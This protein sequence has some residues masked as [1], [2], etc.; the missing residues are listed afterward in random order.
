MLDKRLIRRQDVHAKILPDG[1]VLLQDKETN[2]VYTLTPLAGMVWEF[3]DGNNLLEDVVG[4]IREI[5][6][7]GGEPGLEENLT[8][9]VADME[10][11]GLLVGCERTMAITQE[12]E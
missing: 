2:W 3:C 8:E 11:A 6:E 7:V 10:Q 9:L 4:H 12:K 1:Y 5:K